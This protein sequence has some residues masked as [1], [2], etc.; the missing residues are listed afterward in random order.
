MPDEFADPIARLLVLLSYFVHRFLDNMLPQ[1][2]VLTTGL[3]L[4]EKHL[5]AF[6]QYSPFVGVFRSLL[7]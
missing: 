5:L 7:A 2:K 6:E 3:H 1:R 4:K